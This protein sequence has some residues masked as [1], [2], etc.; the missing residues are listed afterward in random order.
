MGK[1]IASLPMYDLPELR[2]FTDAWWAALARAFR[3]T[4]VH[5]IPKHLDRDRPFGTEWLDPSLLFSQ[6]CGMDYVTGGQKYLRLLATPSYA[7]PF[8]QGPYYCSVLIVRTDDPAQN[9]ADL[10]QRRV[11]VNVPGSHSG[12][13]ILRAMV[14]PIARGG[15]F[16]NTVLQSG[17]HANSVCAVQNK[18]ADCAAI[19]CVSFALLQR[20]RSTACEGL[21]ILTVSPPAPS[22][23]YV[24]SSTTDADQIRRLQDGLQT[25]LLDPRLADVREAILLQGAEHLSPNA[26]QPIADA[27]TRAA[28]LGYPELI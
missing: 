13:N 8:C 14:A 27:T 20:Y 1:G 26:Y 28:R 22:L 21:R 25:A 16:F 5:G 2:E 11:A 18:T 23:P 12:Y 7:A 6:C 17:S 24:T 10:H 3:Q 15:T 19:D 9:L 4:G